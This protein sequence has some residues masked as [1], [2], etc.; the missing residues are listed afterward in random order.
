MVKPRACLKCKTIFEEE[1]CPHCGDTA[2]TESF[3][4]EAVI[5]NPEKSIIAH[6]LKINHKGK[7]ALKIK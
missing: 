3:K 4:G 7:V 5:F 2:F 1:K 6:N